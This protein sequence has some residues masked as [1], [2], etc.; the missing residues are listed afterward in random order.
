MRYNV[1]SVVC[2]YGIYEN[3]KLILILN[4]RH[5]AIIICDILNKDFEHKIYD[6]KE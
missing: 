5:N 3:N 1:K 6:K 2:D 4:S